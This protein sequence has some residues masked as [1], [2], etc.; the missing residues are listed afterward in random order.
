MEEPA[1][2]DDQRVA[3]K[4]LRQRLDPV[5]R[6][7][8][9]RSLK[10][11]ATPAGGFVADLMQR[12]KEAA[13]GVA[14]SAIAFRLFLFFVP[15]LLFVVGVAGLIAGYV[16]AHDV[17]KTVGASGGLARQIRA[18]MAE[19]GAARWVA[20]GLGLLGMLTA[21]RSFSKVL[22]STAAIAWQVPTPKRTSLR[23]LGTVAGLVCVMG[24]LSII[25][26]RLREEYGL[27]VA[28][29]SLIPAFFVYVVAWLG[30]SSFLP[31]GTSDPGALLPGSLLVAFSIT[32]MQGL[33]ELYLPDKISRAGE[34]YWSNR[35]HCRDPWVVLLS[36]SIHCAVH[37][38][39]CRRIQP[40][41]ERFH[42][43][44]FASGDPVTP[45]PLCENSEVLRPRRR[46]VGGS[47]RRSSHYGVAEA[48]DDRG[49]VP[50]PGTT[51]LTT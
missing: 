48:S 17:E 46:G 47:M 28:G 20:T 22:I 33:S 51:A 32:A 21:G 13:G 9:D 7:V 23:T 41:R 2:V 45:S 40:L 14:G 26:N 31:R 18:A 25:V 50:T 39:Q 19:P 15:L 37:R 42:S 38:D 29:P 5:I 44:L 27:S 35:G 4:R 34:L 8:N 36:R 16:S 49:D 3:A 6:W 30:L 1:E 11:R 24:L 43:L 10:Y 12:D